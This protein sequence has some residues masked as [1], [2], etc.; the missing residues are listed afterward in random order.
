M[1]LSNLLPQGP[2]NPEEEDWGKYKKP[3]MEDTKRARP[4]KSIWSQL[5]NS[6]T[7][8]ACACLK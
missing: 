1:S 3:G 8:G 7:E 5:V 2:G 4:S 6:E